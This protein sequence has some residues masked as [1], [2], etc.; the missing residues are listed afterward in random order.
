MTTMQELTYRLRCVNHVND[1][2]RA[3]ADVRYKTP[4]Q[5]AQ[6]ARWRAVRRALFHDIEM[7]RQTL[8]AGTQVALLPTELDGELAFR[9][10][11][12]QWDRFE[13]RSATE[14]LNEGVEGRSDLY[15]KVL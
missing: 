12:T 10:Q 2:L 15:G 8:P 3:A 6:V 13:G 4:A 9:W 14:P 7:L 5:T 1:L 11:V